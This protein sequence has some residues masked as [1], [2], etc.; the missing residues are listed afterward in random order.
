[1]A[2]CCHVCSSAAVCV[3]TLPTRMLR[4][5]VAGQDADATARPESNLPL[6]PP[7]QTGPV[8]R[9]GRKRKS[10]SVGEVIRLPLSLSLCLW[11]PNAR[12]QTTEVV[13][14]ATDAG[15][16]DFLTPYA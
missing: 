8:W 4:S 6:P 10:N 15:E 1:M 9:S 16:L 14:P 5:S 7:P 12:K 13:Q 3:T 2:L 11:R